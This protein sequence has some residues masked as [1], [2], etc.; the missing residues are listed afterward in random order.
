MKIETMTLADLNL[1]VRTMNMVCRCGIRDPASLYR[2][3]QEDRDNLVR[4]CGSHAVQEIG[5]ALERIQSAS[6][7][8]DDFFTDDVPENATI[9]DANPE[10]KARAIYLRDH[11][12]AHLAAMQAN[13]YEVCKAMKE[14]RDGKLYKEL[15]YRNFEDCC[16]TEFGLTRMQSYKYIKIANNLSEDFVKSTLQIGTEKLSLLAMLDEDGREELTA[17]VDVSDS[18]VRELK[19]EIDKLK[20]E[21]DAAEQGKQNALAEVEQS[22]QQIEQLQK[23]KAELVDEN[24][25]LT[26]KWMTLDRELEEARNAPVE[27]AVAED[28]ESK[29]ELERVRGMMEQMSAG[30]SQKELEIEE[31]IRKEYEDKLTAAR[32]SGDGKQVYKFLVESS[33]QSVSR[34]RSFLKQNPTFCSYEEKERIDQMLEFFFSQLEGI[35]NG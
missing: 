23:D 2:A 7:E 29:K 27:H 8:E 33:R 21:K 18:S 3:Y 12:K 1:S 14:M 13:L 25:Y 34:L 30:F 26:D 19:A 11:V 4:N 6:E 5:G 16:K 28:T 32:N 22:K 35:Q 15:G 17:R 20:A 10:Q 31:R 9:I 24:E